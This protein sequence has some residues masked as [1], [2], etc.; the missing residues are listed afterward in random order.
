MRGLVL[1]FFRILRVL[2]IRSGRRIF[3]LDMPGFGKAEHLCSRKDTDLLWSE[4]KKFTVFPFRVVVREREEGYG[5]KLLIV[6]RKK[7]FH[8]AVD[9]NRWRRLI[10]EA[11]RRQKVVVSNLNADVGIMVISDEIIEYAKVYAKMQKVLERIAEGDKLP[12]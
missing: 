10:R 8:H 11:Y 6:V 7:N 3:I 4:G 1:P 9:R 12:V 2:F 5:V